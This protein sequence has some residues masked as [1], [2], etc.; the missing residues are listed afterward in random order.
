MKL[1]V[2]HIKEILFL[3]LVGVNYYQFNEV[4]NLQSFQVI[5]HKHKFSITRGDL[6]YFK[7]SNRS[8]ESKRNLISVLED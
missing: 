7:A 4:W 8:S 3:S 2:S 1:L 5:L 6:N